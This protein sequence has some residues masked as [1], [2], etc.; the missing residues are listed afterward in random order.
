MNAAARPFTVQDTTALLSPGP[1]ASLA[2]GPGNVG[3]GGVAGMAI[4]NAGGMIRDLDLFAGFWDYDATRI[5]WLKGFLCDQMMIDWFEELA[6]PPEEGE[7]PEELFSRASMNTLEGNL[8][9][10]R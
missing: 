1:Q 3:R 9:D 5:D 7:E 4:W 6:N 2:R 8:D 10:G